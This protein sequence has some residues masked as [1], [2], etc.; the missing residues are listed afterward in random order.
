[1]KGVRC[2]ALGWV[3]QRLW[4]GLVAD[5]ATLCVADM[6]LDSICRPFTSACHFTISTCFFAWQA[7]YLGHWGGF[8]DGLI[9]NWSSVTPRYFACQ[10]WNFA[11]ILR[12]R[13]GFWWY[14]SSFCVEGVVLKNI[15]FR[16]RTTL[17]HIIFH[18]YHCHTLSFPHYRYL[19]FRFFATSL[20]FPPSPSPLQDLVFIIGRSFFVGLSRF[21]LLVMSKVEFNI[22]FC[23]WG[24]VI[25]TFLFLW[26]FPIKIIIYL[27]NYF[28]YI[29]IYLFNFFINLKI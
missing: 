23:I 12:G 26:L 21:L 3:W 6:G 1:M 15:Y 28:I 14:L 7:W 22:L 5:V 29:F 8:G 19:I 25:V 2:R 16:L 13:R 24:V 27:F 4:T 17:S 20:F 10:A 11:F 18:I 9:I